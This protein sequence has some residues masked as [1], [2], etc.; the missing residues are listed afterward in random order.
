MVKG[1]IQIQLSNNG[2][3]FEFK[4]NQFGDMVKY[5]FL[6]FRSDGQIKVTLKDNKLYNL[7][8]WGIPQKGT[9]MAWEGIK[10]D[11]L[12]LLPISSFISDI[13][14]EVKEPPKPKELF[15]MAKWDMNYQYWEQDPV[16]NIP[17]PEQKM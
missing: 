3:I 7:I 11:N 15:L 4:I 8:A 2:L 16:E 14:A 12:G 9:F 1:T 5:G 6:M 10:F 13:I 17:T